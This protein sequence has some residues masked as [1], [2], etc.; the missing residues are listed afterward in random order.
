[1]KRL[2]CLLTTVGLLIGCLGWL[3][4]PSS[5]FA[6]TLGN[7]A[8]QPVHLIT[9]AP[10]VLA[11][12]GIRDVVGEKLQTEYGKKID[13]NNTNVRAFRQYPG[14]YPT[15]AGLVVKNAPYENVED[16]LQIAG[17]TDSQKELL[18]SNLDKFTVTDVENALVEGGDRINNG[19]YR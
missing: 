7:A 4:M 16:V 12:E 10:T 1:M 8:G 6:G 18:Q 9:F 3:G 11:A 2:V 17:L 15:L 14:M 5:A 19:I 13:L